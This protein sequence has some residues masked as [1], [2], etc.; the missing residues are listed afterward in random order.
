MADYYPLLVRALEGLA[1]N[2]PEARRIV[3]ERA[4]SAL[5]S[6]LRSLQPP[7]SEAEIE[8]E[9]ASLGEAIERAEIAYGSRPESA[10][11]EG[12]AGADPGAA[13]DDDRGRR[14][15]IENSPVIRKG[16]RRGRSLA[17]AL[18]LVAVIGPIAVAAWLWR[19]DA[20][21]PASPP[22]AP[23]PRSVQ[24]GGDSK[25]ADR[26]TGGPEPQTQPARS[27]P[28]IAQ[29]P[30]APSDPVRPVTQPTP[31]PQSQ[32]SPAAP[33]PAPSAAGPPVSTPPSALPVQPDLAVAQ[34]AVMILE[35]PSDPQAPKVSA[36]RALW[37][38]DAVNSG[39]GQLLETVVRSTVEFAEEGLTLTL[40]MRRN[41]DATLPASHTIELT[42]ASSPTSGP[43]R[44]VRDVGLPQVRT[45]ET[46]R[47][48]ALAGL[49]VP[50]KENVFLIG[51]S[52]LRSDVERNSGLLQRGNW[53][54][55]QMRF[56]SGARAN[57]SFEKGISGERVLT[58]AFRQ[59]DAA[60]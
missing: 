16:G 33:P 43:G 5:L 32:V 23:A 49:S 28:T 58:E 15:G 52:D 47:G 46:A 31:P 41:A 12:P 13:P 11:R 1:D 30:P 3:Y 21:L 45:D 40:A 51:L 22:P 34:R 48:A 38:I 39:Q 50:V 18:A 54:D 55:L 59:W 4:K 56:A 26:V 10:E 2:A 27:A 37:R 42:F 7:L 36:G 57:L 14:P 53:I 35:N 17:V 20:T 19:D 8:R 24:A 60:R 6:Q 29:A 44:A 9:R 25:I